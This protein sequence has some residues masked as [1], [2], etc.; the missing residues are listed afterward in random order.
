[1]M[2]YI[3]IELNDVGQFVLTTGG[4]FVFITNNV[5]EVFKWI[6]ELY[7]HLAFFPDEKKYYE[8]PIPFSEFV[9][10][11]SS[12]KTNNKSEKFFQELPETC[13]NYQF[14]GFFKYGFNDSFSTIAK[15]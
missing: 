4:G 1:M 9:K 10:K 8:N 11:Y 2:K 7:K 15:K 5:L 14:R 3:K 12:K 13:Y 6:K